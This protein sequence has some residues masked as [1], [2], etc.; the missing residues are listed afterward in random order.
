M[1]VA[2]NMYNKARYAVDPEFRQR[3]LD[4]TKAWQKK[5][6]ETEEFKEKRREISK[7]YYQNN[8]DYREKQKAAVRMRRLLMKQQAKP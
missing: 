3:T 7:R 2:C 1:S 4:R 8:P 5:V 6:Q